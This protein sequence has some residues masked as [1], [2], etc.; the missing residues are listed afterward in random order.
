MKLIIKKI[1]FTLLLFS[2]QAVSAQESQ[3]EQCLDYTRKN[4]DGNGRTVVP[5]ECPALIKSAA[6]PLLNRISTGIF[7]YEGVL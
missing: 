6:T 2:A 7:A 3:V 5:R 4:G 1:T